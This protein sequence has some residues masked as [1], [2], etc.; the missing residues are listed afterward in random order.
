MTLALPQG[1]SIRAPTID[2]A[3]AVAALANTCTFAEQGT[4][5]GIPTMAA[6][7]VRAFWQTP[8]VNLATDTWTVVTDEGRLI[9]YADVYQ[10]A[11]VAFYTEGWTHSEYCGRGIGTYLLRLVEARARQQISAAPPHARISI[12]T[13]SISN[14]NDAARRLVEQEGY[15]LVRHTWEMKIEMDTAPPAPD[16]PEGIRVRT[17][18]PQ[19]LPAVYTA[20]EEAFQDHWNY[21]RTSFEEWEQRP[22]REGFDPTLWFLALDG[23]EIAGAALCRYH[24]EM[25]WVGRV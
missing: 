13:A 8:G 9:A 15:K 22:K 4:P 7:E 11:Y 23:E 16:W 12:Q 14:K 18:I 2:D 25:A 1:L 5:Q 6:E 20:V 19:D 17:F 3:E 10:R 24:A 21:T